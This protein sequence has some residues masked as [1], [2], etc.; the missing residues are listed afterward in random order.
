VVLLGGCAASATYRSADG[1][2]EQTCVKRVATGAGTSLYTGTIIDAAWALFVEAPIYTADSITAG[3][4]YAK[5]KSDLE[6]AGYVRKEVK[7]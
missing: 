4:E 5:C 6:E 1:T 2:V 7:P 3:S